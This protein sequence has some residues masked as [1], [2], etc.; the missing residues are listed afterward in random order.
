MPRQNGATEKLSAAALPREFLPKPY[1]GRPGSLK[2]WVHS[3][4]TALDSHQLRL[5]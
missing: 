5:A 4:G 2:I 1:E 3:C